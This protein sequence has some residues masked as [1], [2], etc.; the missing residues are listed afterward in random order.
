MEAYLRCDGYALNDGKPTSYDQLIERLLGSEEL[1]INSVFSAQKSR[2][3]SSLSANQRREL[4]YE[5][6]RL[7]QYEVYCQEAKVKIRSI[8]LEHSLKKGEINQLESQCKKLKSIEEDYNRIV[9]ENVTL[10]NEIIIHE[11]QIQLCRSNI[12]EMHKEEALLNEKIN[13]QAILNGN[14]AALSEDLIN[15]EKNIE[16]RLNALFEERDEALKRESDKSGASN[17]LKAERSRLEYEI[18]QVNSHDHWVIIKHEIESLQLENIKLKEEIKLLQEYSAQEEEVDRLILTRDTLREES[19]KLTESELSLSTELTR[20]QHEEK[21]EA[22]LILPL[23]EGIQIV[24]NELVELTNQF[25]MFTSDRE[26]LIS[27]NREKLESIEHEIKTLDLVPCEEMVAMNC[28]LI[29]NAYLRKESIEPLRKDYEKI[30]SA[31][32]V[33][34]SKTSSEIDDRNNSFNRKTIE[35]QNSEKALT[36]KYQRLYGQIQAKQDRIKITKSSKLKELEILE[37]SKLDFRKK[38]IDDYKI[39][40]SSSLIKIENN[41][42]L[43]LVKIDLLNEISLKENSNLEALNN[44]IKDIINQIEN[45]EAQKISAIE[46]LKSQYVQKEIALKNEELFRCD[47]FNKLIA[48]AQIKLDPMLNNKLIILKENLRKLENSMQLQLTELATLQKKIME[49]QGKILLHSEELK[50]KEEI[51]ISL[52][53]SHLALKQLE[54]EHADYHFLER[55]FDKTGIPVLKLEN[56]GYEITSL[57]ND[58]LKYFDNDFRIVFET[59]RPTKDKKKMK[60]VFDI[61]VIDSEGICELKNKSGGERVWIETSIQLAIGILLRHQGKNLQTSFLDE[62]DGSLDIENALN[63]RQMIESAHRRADVFNTIIITHRQEL[64]ELISQKILLDE[65]G[66]RIILN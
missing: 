57:A 55:A 44:K 39:L 2:G 6:L 61:N 20:I 14:I 43:I 5:L 1:F 41:E 63:Y 19:T 56:T 50:R 4:F 18:Q 11:E 65:E 12:E 35:L 10:S 54:K 42:N 53:S 21:Q 9:I 38:K 28:P 45:L 40:S 36:I 60:E 23:Y 59:M 30:L 22:N 15:V 62:Q 32:G 34:L 51:E 33:R 58:L 17:S 31:F 26:S 52:I 47:H 66:I 24:K 49:H 3:I 16:D 27:T 8:E 46:S 7:N 25:K 64:L 48:E 37:A 13:Q 29:K